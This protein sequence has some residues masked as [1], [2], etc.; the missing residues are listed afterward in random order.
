MVTAVVAAAG[1]GRR[2]GAGSNK[3]FSLL[4]GRPILDHTLAAVTACPEVGAVVVVTGREDLS[5]AAAL[6]ANWPKVVEVCEG[7]QERTDSIRNAL[8]RIPETTEWVAVHDGARPLATP[9]LFRRTIE[10]ARAHGAALPGLPV[11]DTLK[12][13]SNGEDLHETVDRRGLYTVQTPQVFRRELLDRAYAGYD[14]ASPVTDDATLVERLGNP[15]RLVPGERDNLKITTPED[16]ELAERILASG[17]VRIGFGYDTH[18]LVEGRRLI[19]G[20]VELEHSRG[21]EGWSDADVLVHAISDALLGA[22]ALGDIGQHFPNSDPRYRDADSLMLLGEV[23]SLLEAAGW[24]VGNVDA[25]LIAE[26][27]KIADRSLEMRTLIAAALRVDV[28]RVSVKATTNER[29]GYTGREEGMAAHAT[30]LIR[31]RR[32]GDC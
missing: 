13:S 21:L 15:V 14:S 31:R 27:P 24:F 16:L 23:R 20:G 26:R 19:L 29:L 28:S 22:A 9:A 2:F 1:R 10:A 11:T 18:R 12:R 7:G 32:I 6:A 8:A 3:V 25:T 30:A 17:E 4:S 5:R